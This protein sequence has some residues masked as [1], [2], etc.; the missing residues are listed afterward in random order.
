VPVAPTFFFGSAIIKVL[1]FKAQF[2]YH[3][4]IYVGQK[5]YGE[6]IGYHG[7]VRVIKKAKS[8]D[9]ALEKTNHIFFLC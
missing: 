4:T 3:S 2:R 6:E 5:L 7:V 9:W 8:N 1:S